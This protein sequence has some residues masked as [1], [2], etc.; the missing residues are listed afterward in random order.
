M[1]TVRQRVA[2]VRRRD[3]VPEVLGFTLDDAAVAE[4]ERAREAATGFKAR[5]PLLA[6]VAYEM[7]CWLLDAIFAGRP[8]PRF[9]FLETIA[10][11]PYFS[12][13]SVLH[14]YET[15]GWLHIA[16]LRKVHFAEE[17]NE[18]HHLLIMSALG[19]DERWGDRLLAFH[20]SLVYYWGLV[21]VYLVS[22]A[23][24]YSFSELLEIHAVDTY[25]QFVEENAE[26][27]RDL[28]APDVA[29]RY[30]REG[31][32][33][34][35]DE[36]HT[37]PRQSVRRPPVDNL[38]DVFAN[39]RDDESEHVKTMAACQDY[40]RIGELVSSPHARRAAA[41]ASGDGSGGTD[42]R[43]VGELDTAASARDAPH[44]GE[45][46]ST[47]ARWLR[48]AETLNAET[49]PDDTP[50]STAHGAAGAQGAAGDAAPSAKTSAPRRRADA[51]PDDD[52]DDDGDG[53]GGGGSAAPR[54]PAQTSPP[55][56]R[57]GV[58]LLGDDG[59]DEYD[60]GLGL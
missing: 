34:M 55:A 13:I 6:R 31:D 20:L 2:G 30:Y 8:I 51:V 9:W 45:E 16:E 10:R 12:F 37:A 54:D 60:D 58:L 25:T 28:P 38:Y 4:R 53:G 1:R 33:Y 18:M 56:A 26:R 49:T 41:G 21:L 36:F 29:V 52:S 57:A 48:W 19:G 22:P 27:L 24:S 17:W 39:I 14:L 23:M 15:L 7:A 35:F 32:L 44:D 42:E 11:M 3:L 40:D 5:A 43:A 47:R 46:D 59:L 50:S